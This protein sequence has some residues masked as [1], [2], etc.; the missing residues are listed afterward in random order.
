MMAEGAWMAVV[1]GN[2][3]GNERL[4]ASSSLNGGGQSTGGRCAADKHTRQKN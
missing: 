1:P 3:C 4:R 2:V